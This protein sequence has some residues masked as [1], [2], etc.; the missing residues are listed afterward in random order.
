MFKSEFQGFM[1]FKLQQSS[2]IVR[3]VIL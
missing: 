2:S 1:V 3:D